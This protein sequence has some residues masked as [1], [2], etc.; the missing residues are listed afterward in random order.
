MC[1]IHLCKTF[2]EYGEPDGLKVPHSDDGC[3]TGQKVPARGCG[4]AGPAPRATNDIPRS[5]TGENG[6]TCIGSASD[7]GLAIGNHMDKEKDR[8]TQI[9]WTN[10]SARLRCR[11]PDCR[12]SR[13]QTRGQPKNIIFMVAYGMS[14]SVLPMAE[15]FSQLVRGKGL[16]RRR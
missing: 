12:G 15:H 9:L 11:I 7:Q 1:K 3:R 16:L 8:Q 4:Q 6:N 13:R 2:W 14:P 5:V 10:W